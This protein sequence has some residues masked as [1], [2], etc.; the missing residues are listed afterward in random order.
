VLTDGVQVTGDPVNVCAR[1]AGTGTGGEIRLTEEAL[2]EVTD[3]AMRVS[4]RRLPKTELKG[5]G[6]AVEILVLEWRDQQRF[7]SLVTVAETH[8]KITLPDQ[9]VIAF[10]RLATHEGLAANDIVL[11]HPDAN[12]VAQISRWHFELRRH[13]EGLL[14]RAMS[15]QV[16]EVDGVVVPKGTEAPVRAGSTV[17]LAKVLTL[18]FQSPAPVEKSSVR[19]QMIQIKV[20]APV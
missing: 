20:E 11:Q 17:V 9:D 5:L 13:A 10:G 14:L 19:T 15:D 1:V 6:R 16:T 8:E 7:P 12:V 3:A 2:R 4:C 18:H